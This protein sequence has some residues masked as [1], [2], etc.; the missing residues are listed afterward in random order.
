MTIENSKFTIKPKDAARLSR[1]GNEWDFAKIIETKVDPNY[2]VSKII[3]NA[4]H[5]QIDWN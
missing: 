5:W 4:L 1:M 2:K 3:S